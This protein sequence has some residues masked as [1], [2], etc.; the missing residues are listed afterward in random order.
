[1]TGCQA[2]LVVLVPAPACMVIVSQSIWIIYVCNAGMSPRWPE[3]T[4][5]TVFS[6]V[7]GIVV[8][9]LGLEDLAKI[10]N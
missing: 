9:L 2:V 10:C 5:V 8:R 7:G 6:S 1:M 4:Y 3:G